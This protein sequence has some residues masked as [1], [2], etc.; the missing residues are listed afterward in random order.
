VRQLARRSALNARAREGSLLVVER[1]DFDGP[2]TARLVE[3][4]AKLGAA[5]RKSLVLTREGDRNVWL[6]GRNIPSVS[7]RPWSEATAYEILWADLLVVEQGAITGEAPA[8]VTEEA[9]ETGETGTTRKT[10]A[11]RT[12]A[13]SAKAAKAAKKSAKTAK[14]A[15]AKKP[16]A[17]KATRK[18]AA[19][20]SATRAA[21]PTTRKKKETE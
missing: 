17:K 9:G 1:F 3:L 11:R 4:L 8:V 6:S 10:T 21:K 19:R 20:K 16:A 15:S 12:P 13:K 14:K 18:S 5:G 2:K 7:V